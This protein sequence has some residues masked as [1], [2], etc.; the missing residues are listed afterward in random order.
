[1][2]VHPLELQNTGEGTDLLEVSFALALEES[3]P[4]IGA[5]LDVLKPTGLAE[6]DGCF[7]SC[8]LVDVEEVGVGVTEPLEP[9][10]LGVA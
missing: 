4:E 10:R 8:V 9:G 6:L 5:G 3:P 2:S 7:D 1:M